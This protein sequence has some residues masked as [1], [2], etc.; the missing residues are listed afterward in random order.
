MP[1]DSQTYQVLIASPSDLGEE[2]QT[3]RDVINDWNADHASAES[4]VL[5]PVMWESQVTPT[6]GV[7]PQSAINTQIVQD[8][9]ILIGMFWTKLGTST[10][11]AASGTVEE[12]DQ[13]V[14]TRRPTLL[15]FSARPVNP[16]AIDTK[17]LDQLREFKSETYNRA[18][19]GGF[20]SLD[21][22]R[23]ILSRDLLNQVRA[24]HASQQRGPVQELDLADR[25]TGLIRMHR[26]HNITLEEF[27]RYRELIGLETVA[28]PFPPDPLTPGEVGPN[29]YPVGYSDTGDKV[30]WLPSDDPDAPDDWPMILRRSDNAISEAHAEHWDKV[31]YGRHMSWR[32]RLESG[33]EE[34][35]EVMQPIFER[36]KMAADRIERQYGKENLGFNDFER[37][38]VSGRLSALAWIQGM[39][40]HESLDT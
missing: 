18:L 31:W 9:D 12:I 40:W 17:Q 4:V 33:E 38:L 27:A 10:G 2:R 1:F 35:S 30:E 14:E 3:V 5:L 22:L 36:A 32:Y 25:L 16:S 34:L 23:R 37:G 19:V 39:E 26:E 15:Y 13:F 20:A 11:V 6:A 7:R 28:A 8:A 29:G 24:M 21:E